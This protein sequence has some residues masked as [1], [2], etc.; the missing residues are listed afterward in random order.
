MST[1]VDGTRVDLQ[2]AGGNKCVMFQVDHDANYNDYRVQ[3]IAGAGTFRF[4]FC[5][6]P[7]FKNLVSLE[8]IC[9]PDAGAAGA[10]KNIDL[11]SDYGGPGES[12]T[13]HSQAN[14]TA[15]YNLGTADTWQSID[16]APLF[17]SLAASDRCGLLVD[18]KTIGGTNRYI[19]VKM[20][21]GA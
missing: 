2:P 18:H 16:I 21:Y 7:D 9:A 17:S 12:T 8:L 19:G 10:A 15:T 20:V 14:T 13:Q 6:P 3:N 4:S 1:K 5:A 11:Y